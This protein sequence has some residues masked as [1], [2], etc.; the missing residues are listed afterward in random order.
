MPDTDL[1][2]AAARLAA[3]DCTCVFCRGTVQHVFTDRGVQPLLACLDAALPLKGFAAAD[4]IVGRAA[5]FLYL[6]L[7]VRA[8]YAP[9]MSEGAAAL[10]TQHG[11]IAQYGE[12]VLAIRNRTH[13]GLCPMETAVAGLDD[14][15]GALAAIRRTAAAL[16]DRTKSENT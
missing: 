13:T 16:A 15:A 7:G 3:G 6:L 14:P 8:V 9:V 11:I 10:L 1:T 5:A 4:R 12:T 2:R